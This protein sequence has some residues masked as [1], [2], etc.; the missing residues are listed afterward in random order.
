MNAPTAVR[1]A[2]VAL[3]VWVL[4]AVLTVP[5][6]ALAHPPAGTPPSG[7]ATQDTGCLGP[8]RSLI[9]S[10]ALAGVQLPDGFVVPEGFSRTFNP[11]GH[12]GTVQEAQFLASHGVTDLDAFCRQFAP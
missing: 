5:A 7:F 10:G 3:L 1:S 12:F 11:G 4:L 6:L 2:V 8:L 9:G